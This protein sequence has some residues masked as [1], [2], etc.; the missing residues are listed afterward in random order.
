MVCVIG[1]HDEV[2]D[3][4]DAETETKT[5]AEDCEKNLEHKELGI[6]LDGKKRDECANY[7]ETGSC[8]GTHEDH[9]FARSPVSVSTAQA[10][11]DNHSSVYRDIHV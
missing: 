8:A 11:A 4:L 3:K 5:S 10:H 7:G 6:V 1:V 9:H 2:A